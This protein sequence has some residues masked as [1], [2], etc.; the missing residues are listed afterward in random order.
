MTRIVRLS[1]AILLLLLSISDVALAA[2]PPN[3]MA[4]LQTQLSTMLSS[5]SGDY[6]VT[7]TDLQTDQSIAVNGAHAQTAASTIKLYIAIAI[8][9]QIDTGTISLSAVDE[10]MRS[11]M[12][13]SDNQ[14][15]YELLEMLGNGDVVAGTH[16]INT[17]ARSLGATGSALDSPPDH[18]EIDL[19]I[20]YDN[21][22]TSNDVNLILSKL[23]HGTILSPAET[24]YVLQLMALPADW[25][26]GSVGGPLPPGTT[27]Y[28][29]PGWIDAPFNTWNDAGIVTVMRNGELLAYAITYLASRTPSEDVSYDHGYA[30]S[31]VVWNAFNA[32]YPVETYHYFAETGHSIGNGFLRYWQQNG[33]LEIFGY[34]L[35]DEITQNGTTVQYFERARFE[36][37]P[38]SNPENYDILLGLLGNEVTSVRRASGAAPF[39][40]ATAINSAGCTFFDAT[41]HNLCGGFAAYWARFGGLSIYG[42]P[43]SEEFNENGTTVQYFERA[44]F[45]WHPGS[46]P[47]RFDVLLG[48]LGA[49]ELASSKQSDDR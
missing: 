28:H 16:A 7:V 45:E 27:F 31:Q 37:H 48:R 2:P 34:P 40:P 39:Q 13:V 23:Y 38:G 32:A 22:L 33:G 10:L 29:K 42:Y 26:N 12:A 30:V 1:M 11:M 36:W 17:V 15:A 5:W 18:P 19:G 20:A 14:A 4:S 8:A 46:A 47:Q 3:W 24:A 43:I 41:G 21:L 44:R 9:Q 49:E 25:Q 35:T 6:A